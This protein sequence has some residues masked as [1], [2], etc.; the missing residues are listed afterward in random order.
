MVLSSKAPIHR[1][2][3]QLIELGLCR[4]DSLEP[5]HPVVRDRD[6][7]G[8]LRCRESGVV[9]LDR[10]D[11][12]A[13]GYYTEKTHTDLAA[14]GDRRRVA[15]ALEE[16]TVRRVDRWAP[17]VT[18]KRWLDVGTGAGAIIEAM[19]DRPLSAAAVEPQ[20]EFQELLRTQGFE[21]FADIIDVDDST[22]D[23][24]TLFHVF[25]HL[26]DPMGALGEY[27][28]SLAPGGRI[29]IEVPHA[30]DL[31]LD[32]LGL[33]A[34]K[35]FTL[36]GEHLML[37]T[38]ESLR[39]LLREAGFEQITIRG[40]QRYPLANHLHWLAR[41]APGGHQTWSALRDDDVDNAYSGLLARLDATDTL[42][43]E[44]V[45]PPGS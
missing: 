23:L 35:A 41:N 17:L 37:H 19:G 38:R 39:R 43:A 9:V 20:G 8:A 15:A 25:E 12:I 36:W 14:L 22:I 7:V 40:L 28:R 42:I 18:N 1:I 44:A 11:H 34:F 27:R 4:I 13:D 24:I 16:D 6:D 10:I 30:R 5:F 3:E 21:V 2:H 32:F 26:P 29:V 45:L 33:D 31:L